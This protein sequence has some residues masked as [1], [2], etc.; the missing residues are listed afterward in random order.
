MKIRRF[1]PV[2]LVL[3]LMLALSVSAK[4]ADSSG[5]C[6]ENLTWTLTGGKLTISGTGPMEDYVYLSGGSG[7][8]PWSGMEEQITSIII[9]PGV[10]HI[11]EYAFCDFVNLTSVSIPDTVQSLGR[12]AFLEC[13]SLTGPSPSPTASQKSPTACSCSA[14]P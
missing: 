7:E 5:K 14:T 8:H 3:C 6:G 1:L 2:L 9:E 11:G 4:A 10:T 13:S 12:C